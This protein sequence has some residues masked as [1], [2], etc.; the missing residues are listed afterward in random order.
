VYTVGTSVADREV[1]ADGAAVCDSLEK[2]L[3]TV[4]TAICSGETQCLPSWVK[5]KMGKANEEMYLSTMFL[6]RF[7]VVSEHHANAFASRCSPRLK[8]TKLLFVMR[9]DLKFFVL[10]TYESRDIDGFPLVLGPFKNDILYF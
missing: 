6:V 10:C 1:Y 2:T 4:G 7:V 8:F 3:S 5:R 9:H